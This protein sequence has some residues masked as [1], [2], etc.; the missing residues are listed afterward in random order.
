VG[1][2]GIH[3][4]LCPRYSRKD[5]TDI[6]QHCLQFALCDAA[7][8]SPSARFKRW[9]FLLSHHLL[10][11]LTFYKSEEATD[12]HRLVAMVAPNCAMAMYTYR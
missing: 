7:S 1:R 5:L 9:G 3:T 11:F 8:C 4:I 10:S 2:R 12:D 6:K